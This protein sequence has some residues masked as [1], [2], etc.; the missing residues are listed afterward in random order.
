M[1]AHATPIPFPL[2]YK[3]LHAYARTYARTRTCM[4][5]HTQTY[6]KS[7]YIKALT[8]QVLNIEQTINTRDV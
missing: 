5:L 8:L 3:Y 4:Q 7:S 1:V 6:T 2:T